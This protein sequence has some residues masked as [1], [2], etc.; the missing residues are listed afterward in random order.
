MAV[1]ISSQTQ[2]G[3]LTTEWNRLKGL[4][5]RGWLIEILKYLLLIILAVSFTLPFFWMVTSALKDDSQVY[6]V[7]PVWIPNPAHWNNFWDAWNT[8]DFN[9]YMINTVFK[10]AIP[11]VI[12]TTTSSAVVAYGFSRLRWPGRDVFFFICMATMMVPFQVT[13]VPLFITF[14]HLGW[15][16]TYLPLVVPSFFGS[17]YFIFMLRQFFLTIPEELSDAAR[18]D[19]ASEF[20]ILWQIIL[21]LAKPALTVVALFQFMGAWNDYLGPLI[22]LNQQRL[23]TVALGIENLRRTMSQVGRIELAYPYLMAVS[24]IVTLPIVVAFFFTQRTFIEGISLT[25]MKG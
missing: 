17:A 14:K 5:I 12:G 4:G 23:Y 13:M 16:N 9:L 3:G 1:R 22:Y 19:G 2:T 8:Y 25:G 6:T 20:R 15:I 24:T 18:I 21:P 11:V 10:Y 7:P